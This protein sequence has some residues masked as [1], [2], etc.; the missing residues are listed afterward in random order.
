[1]NNLSKSEELLYQ[2]MGAISKSRLPVVFKGAMVLKLAKSDSNIVRETLDIDCDWINSAPSSKEIENKL[3][4][5]VQKEL[6]NISFKLLRD[7]GQGKSA[8][9]NIYQDNLK[10]SSMDISVRP[11]S[12]SKE[13]Y[14]GEI[15]FVGYEL[16]NI[17]ADKISV[18]SS[19]KIFRRI[20]DFIDLYSICFGDDIDIDEIYRIVK[21]KNREIGNFNALFNRKSE[22]EH[23]YD[24]LRRIEPKPDFEYVYKTII[25]YCIAFKNKE[26]NLKWNHELLKWQQK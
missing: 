16:S 11:L 3:N 5:A 22:I 12:P 9:F 2:I 25:A 26:K 14:I 23:A 24:E 20:K 10:I 8:G 17:V 21:E 6:P 15:E 7:Y 18:V 1:M 4:E 19:D 13:Y